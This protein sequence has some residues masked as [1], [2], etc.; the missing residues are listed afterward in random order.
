VFDFDTMVRKA[1]RAID[2]GDVTVAM[3]YEA[4]RQIIAELRAEGRIAGVVAPDRASFNETPA[5]AGWWVHRAPAWISLRKGGPA[6]LA[7]LGVAPEQRATPCLCLEALT[8]GVRRIVIVDY[9][10]D[11]QQDLPIHD[12]KDVWRHV[13]SNTAKVIGVD[14][15]RCYRQMIDTLGPM[16]RLPKEAFAR[17]RVLLVTGTLGPGGAE[18]QASYTAGLIAERGLRDVHVG[19]VSLAPPADFFRPYVEERGAVIHLVEEFPE[20]SQHPAFQALVRDILTQQPAAGFDHVMWAVLRFAAMIRKVRPGLVHAWMDYSNVLAGLAAA[21]VGVPG[22]VV[23][24]RSMA[25][26]HFHIFQ[27]YMRPGYR[28]LRELAPVEMI[29]NSRAGAADYERWLGLPPSTVRTLHNGF[30]FP[31]TDAA[32]AR[33]VVRGRYGLANE[34]RV[35][36]GLLRFSEEKQP[37]LLIDA[38]AAMIR[39]DASVRALI[40]GAGPLLESE[41]ARVAAMGLTDQIILPGLTD[42][43]EEA[44]AAMDVFMLASR[45]EG[46]P[47]VLVEAQL[48]GV[49]IVCTGVGGMAETFLP[50]ETGLAALCATPEGLAAAA[51]D[52]LLD[53]ARHARM[54]KAAAAFARTHFSIERMVADTL[55]VYSTALNGDVFR[56]EMRGYR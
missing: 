30:E 45:M 12:R 31:T 27:P 22:I 33:P 19:C 43:P 48:M 56:T 1:M 53:P 14:F 25:P 42:Q 55:D 18:R 4:P 8:K 10:G 6:T 26:D 35:V 24:G 47:N 29:N 28:A 20:A 49:P 34:A 46:L 2:D 54:S 36:G 32:Q 11:V 3:P 51:L 40:F 15:A 23:G 21:L 41:R 50:G 52:I 5:A 16:L 38:A 39:R 44:L 17:D 7:I 9:N 13:R 37:G